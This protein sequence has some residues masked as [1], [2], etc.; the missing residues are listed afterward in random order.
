MFSLDVYNAN[1]RPL[2]ASEL[3]KHLTNIVNQSMT[4]SNIPL[5]IMTT[6]HRD[7]WFKVFTQLTKG[8]TKT[9]T[10]FVYNI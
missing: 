4:P 5:G 3:Y 1:G 10:M 7:A 8:F 2:S 9:S 6:E